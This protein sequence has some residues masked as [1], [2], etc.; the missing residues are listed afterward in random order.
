MIV[1][2]SGAMQANQSSI[3]LRSAGVSATPPSPT[4][5]ILQV[6]TYVTTVESRP[7]ICF[8]VV[9]GD[10]ARRPPGAWQVVHFAAKIGWTSVEKLGMGDG[11]VL[12]S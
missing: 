11:Q 5:G 3:V 9:S 1:Q 12:M 8:Q 7:S 2:L 4:L 6:T 10:E